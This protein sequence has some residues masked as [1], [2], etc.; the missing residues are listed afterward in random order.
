M[1][2]LEL[3]Q[4]LMVLLSLFPVTFAGCLAPATYDSRSSPPRLRAL[5]GKAF[6]FIHFRFVA[7]HFPGLFIMHHGVLCFSWIL[8]HFVL[9][10][11]LMAFRSL[12]RQVLHRKIALLL[13]SG[14]IPLGEVLCLCTVITV[15]LRFYSKWSFPGL[16]LASAN[17]KPVIYFWNGAFCSSQILL[18]ASH[19]V[20]LFIF[21]PCCKYTSGLNYKLHHTTRTPEHSWLKFFCLISALPFM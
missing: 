11:L 13:K 19:S 8:L 4:I 18:P 12:C 20:A 10:S 16:D 1:H 15:Y 14:F 6:S 17:S 9:S 7:F 2:N 5:Y 21:E 3:V